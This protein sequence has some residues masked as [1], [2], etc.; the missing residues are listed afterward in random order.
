MATHS[1]TQEQCL[2]FEDAAN[3]HAWVMSADRLHGQAVALRSQYGRAQIVLSSRTGPPVH[4][5]ETGKATFLL[6]AIAL[7]NA[8]KGFLVYEHPEWIADGYLHPVVT[9]HKLTSLAD[10]STLI[11]YTKRDRWILKAFEEGNESWM[12]YPCGRR[13]NDVTIEPSFGDK[14]WFGY[15]RVM[16]GYSRKIRRL[17]E[18]GWKGPHAFEG[19]WTMTGEW[20]GYTPA[21]KSARPSSQA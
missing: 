21:Q 6:C 15:L 13:A 16:T 14:L 3:P 2:R 19:S 1:F 5:D 18:K 7:E 10:K 9:S 8:I 4:W 12:R 20:L 17:L 11:P